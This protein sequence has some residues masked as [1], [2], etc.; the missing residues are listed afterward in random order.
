MDRRRVLLIAAAV[1]AALGTVL[2]FLYVKGADTRAAQQFDTVLVLR[3]I[4]PIEAGETIED[5]AANG[6]LD[7]QP[8]PQSQLLPDYQTSIDGLKGLVALT[9]IYP[10]E[11]IISDKF[12]GQ[13]EAATSLQIP[14]GQLAIS[15]NLTD[16]A[17]VAG[18]V[19]PGSEV[20]V[21]LN[22]ADA[23]TGDPFTRVLLDRVTVLG[24]GSTTPVSTTTTDQS[25]Q[26]TTE[27]LPRTLLTLSL[28][29]K[30]AQ[31]VLFASANGELAFALLTG[32]S[33]VSS[34]PAVTS[35][36]LF[37]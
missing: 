25:G 4:A 16:P 2:V 30:D 5:A 9:R 11:Q 7:S 28:D 33:S 20:A 21:F 37:K 31:R 12:G 32:S 24:V 22:G 14:K 29:Q 17:R 3:A 18:F 13:A 27:Q 15:V 6:K 36:N 19:N 10:G 8:V 23:T 35:L 1:V 34:G 26:Q